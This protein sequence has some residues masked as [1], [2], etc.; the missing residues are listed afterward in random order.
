[1]RIVS[2]LPSSTEIVCLLGLEEN[3][4]GVSHECDFPPRVSKLPRVV[5]SD[6]DPAALSQAEID[7]K[8]R[9]AMK[10]GRAVCEVDEALLASL[11][12][13]LVLTQELCDVCAVPLASATAAAEKV[14]CPPRVLSLHAHALDD[15]LRDIGRVGEATSTSETAARVVAELTARL[16]RVDQALAGI[17]RRPRVA[18]LEWLD[19]LMASGHWVAEMIRRAGGEDFLGRDREPSVCVPWADF[20]RYA[21]ET[22][23]LMPC[24]FDVERSARDVSLLVSRTG[25]A[26]LPAVAAGQIYAVHGGAYFNRPGPRLVDGVEILAEI[27]HPEIFPRRRPK[28]DYRRLDAVAA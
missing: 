9:A 11:S 27:L 14:A 13:D 28:E 18:A 19:P 16:D 15:V 7:E 3:L 2:L 25:W 8:V 24:G 26:A 12:P 22:V 1:M 23:L 20:L 10:A 4:V 21:P 6:F 5:R 17:S